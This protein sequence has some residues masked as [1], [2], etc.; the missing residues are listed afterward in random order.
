MAKKRQSNFE[1]LRLVSMFM[2]VVC[3]VFM[4]GYVK[5]AGSATAD[6]G[7]LFIAYFVS[8]FGRVGNEIFVMISAYFICL[9]GF[10]YRTG[11]VIQT[12]KQVEFWSIAGLIVGIVF[13]SQYITPKSIL[14]GFL[15]IYPL[16][17]WFVWPFLAVV[18]LSPFL[19]LVIDHTEKKDLL[20]LTGSL[21]AMLSIIP[22]L[23]GRLKSGPGFWDVGIFIILY[24]VAALIRKYKILDFLP[25]WMLFLSLVVGVVVQGASIY[26]GIYK[27]FSLH[28]S[29]YIVQ[30]NILNSQES[31]WVMVVAVAIFELFKRTDIGSVELINKSAEASFGIYLIH[32][33]SF[34]HVYIF[35]PIVSEI[36]LPHIGPV[37]FLVIGM[38]MSL[39]MFLALWAIEYGRIRLTVHLNKF[40][41]RLKTKYMFRAHVFK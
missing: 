22:M 20:V 17:Y 27:S 32:F 11:Q 15:P 28:D 18:I 3:H 13:F 26:N 5:Q 35:R 23:I 37:L 8:I 4:F 31:I 33:A 1:L 25:V 12:L 29:R 14:N 6:M 34:I 36:Y 38:S 9:G 16:A 19:N 40:V 2:I 7:N 21:I 39:A 30:G 24:F 41:S 10:K